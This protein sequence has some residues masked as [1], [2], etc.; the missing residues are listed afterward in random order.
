MLVV[1]GVLAFLAGSAVCALI[2]I[3]RHAREAS[4]SARKL[5]LQQA[6]IIK[7]ML[8][9]G[10]RPP[11]RGQDWADAALETQVLGQGSPLDTKWDM[12]RPG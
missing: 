5:H 2:L 11:E 4:V 12:R 9:A 3:A 10:F 6:N 8:R 7:M 1:L